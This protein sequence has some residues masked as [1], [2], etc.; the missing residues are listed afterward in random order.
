MEWQDWMDSVGPWVLP[1][2]TAVL[3]WW[4]YRRKYEAEVND[5]FVNSASKVVAMYEKTFEEWKCR[6]ARL[7]E[8]KSALERRI[9]DLERD[10]KRRYEEVQRRYQ[11]AQR[12]MK[13]L[14]RVVV[15]ILDYT[16]G[17]PPCIDDFVEHLGRISKAD[18][19]FLNRVIDEVNHNS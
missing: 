17:G 7:E 5:V 9:Q 18:R 3:S 11:E 10:Y 4:L 1:I 16:N 12:R 15:G 6:V 19:M 2:I 8:Q 14:A 13:L